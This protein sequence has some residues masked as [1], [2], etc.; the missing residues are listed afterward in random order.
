MGGFQ[1][2]TKKFVLL[3]MTIL[4]LFVSIAFLS[5]FTYAAAE[6]GV[7]VEVEGVSPIINDDKLQAEQMAITDALRKAIEQ[8]LGTLI[9]NQTNAKNY[10]LIEDTIKVQSSGYVSRQEVL[11]RWVDD[12]GYYRV[13]VRATV[14]QDALKQS[15]DALKLTLV[16]AGKPRLMI[17]VP[18]IDVAT[19]ITQSMKD[20]GFPV[21]DPERI[22]QLQKTGMGAPVFDEDEKNLSNLAA[23]FQAEILVVGNIR[24][25][26]IGET[27]GIFAERA[28]LSLRAIRADTGQTLV[29]QTFNARGVDISE[30]LALQKA[31]TNA[32]AQAADFLTEQLG[33]QLVDSARTL[34]IT[35]NG[36]NY[37][38]L[39]QLQRRLKATPNISNVY[40]RNFNNGNALLDLETGL[41][42]DQ[43]ADFISGWKDLNLEIISVS[44]SKIELRRKTL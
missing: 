42:P 26:P 32:C 3:F 2:P 15:V 18:N 20:S 30:N 28:F 35:L 29:S 27:D 12:D 36:I 43:L 34:Q 8:V 44:G 4:I 23:T 7:T 21:V 37:S 19:Q 11:K 9:D 1:L 38:E 22:L 39:Q 31:L 24:K 41:L 13:L 6:E 14:K 40:L 16:R 17:L 33:K 25:E 10:Q 5:S